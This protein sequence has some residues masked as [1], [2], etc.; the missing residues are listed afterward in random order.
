LQ[1]PSDRELVTRF[2]SRGDEDAFRQLFRRHTPRLYA[3]AL[4][5]CGGRPDD[6]DDVV[7]TMW[8][9]AARLAGD[10]EWRSSLPTWLSAIVINCA[11]EQRRARGPLS[12]DDRELARLPA[13]AASPGA[14]IDLERAIAAL[15]D[16]Y[17]EVLVLHDVEGFTHAEIAAALGIAVGTAKSQLFHAR[18]AMRRWLA[19]A[20][21]PGGVLKDEHHAG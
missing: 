4:R 3:L 7:Q 21:A 14:R 6:A 16:G 17:R 12:D 5:L 15:P 13:P 2:V 9:R 11:R 20:G 10:F 8:V 18:R 19:P 1:Q